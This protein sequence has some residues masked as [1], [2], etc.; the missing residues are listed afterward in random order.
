MTKLSKHP[1]VL[2][3]RYKPAI[4]HNGTDYNTHLL[5]QNVKRSAVVWPQTIRRF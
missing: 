3:I 5:R 2:I 4:S 1:Q